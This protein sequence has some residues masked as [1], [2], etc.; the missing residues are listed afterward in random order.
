[1]NSPEGWISD[2]TPGAKVENLAPELPS[3]L[4]EEVYAIQGFYNDISGLS[5]VLQGKGE[6]GVRAKGH[7]DILAKLGSARIKQRA[8][9]VERSLEEI[10]GL[11]VKMM[12]K[13]DEHRYG[14]GENLKDK[15]SA[16]QFTDDFQVHVDAHSASPV[17][18]D[19]NKQT[20]FAL[21]KLGAIDGAA[22]LEGVKPPKTSMLVQR[23]KDTQKQKAAQAQQEMLAA[24]PGKPGLKAA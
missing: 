1:M 3:N 20:Y 19:D 6:T 22:L 11:L 10:G 8:Q 16:A 2:P 21:A 7:A 24:G 12:K 9:D 15:F 4:F 23:W 13:K 17:F 18:V 14:M 5:D